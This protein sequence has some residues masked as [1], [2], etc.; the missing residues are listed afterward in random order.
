MNQMRLAHKSVKLNILTYEWTQKE[1]NVQHLSN[2][3][4]SQNNFATHMEKQLHYQVP[5]VSRNAKGI[6]NEKF[7]PCWTRC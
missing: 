6:C 1:S 7:L 3:L 5:I 2:G 4:P